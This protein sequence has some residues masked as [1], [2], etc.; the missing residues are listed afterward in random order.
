MFEHALAECR[1]GVTKTL[2]HIMHTTEAEFNSLRKDTG[3]AYRGLCEQ[4]QSIESRIAS[5]E[6]KLKD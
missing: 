4:L 1:E 2:S 3:E 6:A 5:L